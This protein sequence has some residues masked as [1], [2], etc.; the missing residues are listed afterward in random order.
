MAFFIIRLLYKNKT[1]A[2]IFHNFVT[3]LSTSTRFF[4]NYVTRPIM[5]SEQKVMIRA[6][7]FNYWGIFQSLWTLQKLGPGL[8]CGP[9]LITNF[10]KTA[11]HN[12]QFG[13]KMNDVLASKLPFLLNFDGKFTETWIVEKQQHGFDVKHFLNDNRR[14]IN[15]Y[16]NFLTVSDHRSR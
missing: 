16:S 13:W 14:V 1:R 5:Q 12:R 10:L 3:S 2:L 6:P 7:A 15:G 9:V 4:F 11:T 8:D